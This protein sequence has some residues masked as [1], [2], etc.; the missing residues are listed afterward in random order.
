MPAA[1][2]WKMVD[3]PEVDPELVDALDAFV[4]D[5]EPS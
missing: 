4:S 2:E 1:I 3:V 5:G